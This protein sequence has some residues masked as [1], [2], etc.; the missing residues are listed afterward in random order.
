[1]ASPEGEG[2]ESSDTTMYDIGNDQCSGNDLDGWEWSSVTP[3]EAEMQGL[4]SSMIG[5]TPV[6][7]DPVFVGT[8]TVNSVPTNHFS[9]QVSGLGSSSGAAVNI[10]QGD[11]WL[12][13]D[14]QYIVKY[15]LILEMSTS[16]DEVMHQEVSIELTDI[17]QPVSIAFPQ[18]CLDMAPT[19]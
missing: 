4:V 8:E 11:Y 13:T 16:A 12:A 17:N 7:D 2:P 5:M 19:P 15:L 6:I 10:N 1:M 18:G 14:G 9:F 3:A